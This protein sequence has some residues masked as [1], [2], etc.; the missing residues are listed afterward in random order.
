MEMQSAPA[1]QEQYLGQVPRFTDDEDNR[2]G[3]SADVNQESASQD[4]SMTEN[5]D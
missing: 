5:E 1:V 2:G 3:G 4:L